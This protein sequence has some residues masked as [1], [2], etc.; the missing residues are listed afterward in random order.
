MKLGKWALLLPGL[1][2]AA[3]GVSTYRI[4]PVQPEPLTQEPVSL[5][6]TALASASPEPSKPNY[7]SAPVQPAP[8]TPDPASIAPTALAS[9]SP[10]PS[11][12]N[13]Q[14]PNMLPIPAGE[15]VMGRIAGRDDVEGGCSDDEK[16]DHP[17]KLSAFKLAETEVTVE[18]YLACV[19]QGGCPPPEWNEKGSDY[20][21]STGKDD[22]HKKMGEALTDPQYPIVGVSWENAVA[23]TTWLNKSQQPNQPFRLPTEAEWEYAARGGDNEQAYPWGNAIGKNKANCSD[24][25]DRFE[26][27]APVGSF[28]PNGFGLKDMHGNVWEWVADWHGDYPAQLASNSKG[29]SKDTLRVLRGGSWYAAHQGTCVCLSGQQHAR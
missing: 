19:Q 15:F 22:H 26:Y 11:K 23:Y 21:I 29:A 27:A 1:G 2:L 5:A 17:V 4:T 10:E 28:V 16:P 24:C 14:F 3:W 13:T 9:A 25:G 7:W 12:A 20:N 6:P 18:Q 8:I